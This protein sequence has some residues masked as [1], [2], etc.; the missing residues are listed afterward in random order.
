M[1]GSFLLEL[2]KAQPNPGGGAAAAYGGAVG[3]A[4]L[5]KVVQLEFNRAQK[6][7]GRTQDWEKGLK[8]VRVLQADMLRLRDEDVLAYM[9]LARARASGIR[10]ELE[11]TVKLALQVPRQIMDKAHEGLELVGLAG[12]KC[13]P[14]LV[15]D[16]LVAAELLGSALQGAY[17]IACANLPL[18]KPGARRESLE[19]KLSQAVQA[20]NEILRQVK[21]ELAIQPDAHCG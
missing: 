12:T 2:A 9:A 20:G 6:N 3:L 10:P 14:H 4:L 7:G 15:S 16:L 13:K 17:H 18:M 1:K 11:T 8:K 5:E 19:E 21:E